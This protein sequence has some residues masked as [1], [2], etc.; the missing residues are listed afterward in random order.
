MLRKLVQDWGLPLR[1]I[2]LVSRMNKG[3]DYVE[4]TSSR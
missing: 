2:G 3:K 4:E 1:E